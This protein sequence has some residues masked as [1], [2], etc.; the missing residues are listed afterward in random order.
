MQTRVWCASIQSFQTVTNETKHPALFYLL[1][2][3]ETGNL[4]SLLK[5]STWGS[6]SN[7]PSTE[8]VPWEGNLAT[9]ERHTHLRQGTGVV[10]WGERGRNTCCAN[11][12]L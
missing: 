10:V 2:L 8:I 4:I 9:R 7:D 11:T 6:Q 5:P 3:C 12:G 1:S